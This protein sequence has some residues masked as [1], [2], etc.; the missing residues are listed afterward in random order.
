MRNLCLAYRLRVTQ[1]CVHALT[2]HIPFDLT[3]PDLSPIPA[4]VTSL[5]LSTCYDPRWRTFS[6]AGGDWQDREPWR[7]PDPQSSWESY[8]EE[9]KQRQLTRWASGG[10]DSPAPCFPD[11]PPQ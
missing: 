2:T 10:I 5:T 1:C 9:E 4:S 3:R 7:L 6:A 8:G 11:P